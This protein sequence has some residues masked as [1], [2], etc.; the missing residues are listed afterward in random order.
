ML[1]CL[2]SFICTAQ[3]AVIVVNALPGETGCDLLDA[4]ES[5]ND[6]M[7]V[8]G[9]TTSGTP[10]LDTIQFASNFN[11]YELFELVLGGVGPIDDGASATPDIDSPINIIGPEDSLFPIKRRV[12]GDAVRLFNVGFDGELGLANLSLQ[13]WGSFGGLV[14]GAVRVFGTLDAENIEIRDSSAAFGAGIWVQSGEVT[15]KSSLLVG[16]RAFEQGGGIGSSSSA[17]VTIFDTTFHGNEAEIGGGVSMADASDSSFSIINAT[18]SGNIADVRG[19]AINAVLSN[20]SQENSFIL[21]N[22]ILAG[23]QSPSS[24]ELHTSGSFNAQRM[25]VRN[26]VVGHSE[27]SYADT[28]N[29]FLLIGNDNILLTEDFNNAPLAS[30]IRPFGNTGGLTQGHLLPPGSPAIDNGL[31]FRSVVSGLFNF[32]FPGCRGEFLSFVAQD[33]RDDQIGAQRPVGDE[34]D[35]GALEFNEPETSCFVVKASNG[36]VINFCL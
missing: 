8:G 21:R 18:F 33:Y 36:N 1:P 6:D 29:G 2:A 16:N 15:L 11:E 24:D 26:N 3:A 4:I 31:P 9:C 23:N 10:G 22:T 17:R 35:I 12:S 7:A 25:D 5:A 28:T 13:D 30:I 14:G 34:C 20:A 19:G 27:V 32:I